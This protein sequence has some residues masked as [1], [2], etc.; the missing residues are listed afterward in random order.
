MIYLDPPSR[1]A[2]KAD[3]AAF[4]DNTLDARITMR[5]RALQDRTRAAAGLPAVPR[6]SAR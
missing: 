6:G 4:Y 1:T 3:L 2:M 5:I